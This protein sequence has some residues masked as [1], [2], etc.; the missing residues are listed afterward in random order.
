[1][2]RKYFRKYLPT[3]ES[4]R[5]Y[6]LI[7]K[8]GGFLHRH[9]NLWHLNRRSVSGGVAVGMLCGLIPGPLQMLGAA[10]IAIPLGVNLPVAL[11]TTLYTNPLTIVPL[12]LFAYWLGSLVTGDGGK[13]AEPPEF[14][15]TEI[16]PWIHALADW[17]L[18]LGKPL[19]IGLVLLAASLAA[20][21]WIAVQVAWRAWVVILRRARRDRGIVGDDDVARPQ[22]AV[23]REHQLEH[24]RRRMTVE[25]ARRLIGKHACGPRHQRARERRALALAAGELARRVVEA[26]AQAHLAQD[27]RGLRAGRGPCHPPDEERHRDVVDRGELHQQMMEL[28]DEAER[29]VAQSAALGVG[30]RRHG[31]SHHLDFARRGRVEP[32][33]KV[34][35]RAL[36]RAGGAD[37]RDDLSRSHVQV[38]PD[39]YRHR[40]AGI[41]IR[42]LQ[43]AAGDD[44]SHSYLSASAGRTR[45]ARQLG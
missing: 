25:V 18:A 45:E 5:S 35:Q 11:I 14:A 9:P 17:S 31:P 24:R 13:M 7:A 38:D 36:A 20:L 29:L 21:G 30:Q 42:L 33:Q 23:E 16:G 28:V 32:A 27:R 3:H 37:D 2:P 4:V 6:K 10:L 12:Y 44:R 1:M 43:A 40:H 8:F 22:R 19:A 15:W 34:Q 39:Q 26:L 41:A